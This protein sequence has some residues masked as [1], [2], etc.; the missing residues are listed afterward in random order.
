MEI[1]KLS[2]KLLDF[3][4][5]HSNISSKINGKSIFVK[6]DSH[7]F[8]I[9]SYSLFLRKNQLDRRMKG[10]ASSKHSLLRYA[11]AAKETGHKGHGK[12]ST[13]LE[14]APKEIG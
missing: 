13:N 3:W 5:L 4:S 6:Y 8:R 11:R 9:I 12:D 1:Q 14:T 10:Q 2:P 7:G